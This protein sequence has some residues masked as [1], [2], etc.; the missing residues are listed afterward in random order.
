MSDGVNTPSKLGA[1]GG[2]E[3]GQT[4]QKGRFRVKKMG[5][6]PNLLLTFPN[7]RMRVT[8]DIQPKRKENAMEA[9]QF[10]TLLTILRIVVPFGLVL[11]LGEWLRRHEANNWL[12]T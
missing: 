4:S 12:S 1:H 10:I 3:A 6:I 7:H 11:L 2:N 9:A 5:G 8:K